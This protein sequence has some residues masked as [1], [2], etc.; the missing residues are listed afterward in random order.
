MMYRPKLVIL[1][2]LMVCGSAG[3]QRDFSQV[4]IEPF[5]VAEGIYMLQGQ[6]GNIGLSIGKDGALII[7]DQFAPL[8][9]KI[10]VAI[11]E[12]GGSEPAFI[13]NTHHHGDHTGGNAIFGDRGVI[14]AHEIAGP[15]SE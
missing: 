2:A 6:G 5:K 12:L 1:A 8:A 11:Q 4:R 3:A 13:L 7:D 9:P 14:V 15:T 10:Q